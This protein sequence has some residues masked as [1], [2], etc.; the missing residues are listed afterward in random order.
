MKKL[1]HIAS[2]VFLLTGIVFPGSAKNRDGI[3]TSSSVNISNVI[4]AAGT[5]VS[6]PVKVQGLSNIGAISL[7]IPYNS[8]LTFTSITTNTGL[9]F[10][11][12]ASGGVISIAWVDFTGN[13]P[14]TFT[15]GSTLLYLNFT[16][17]SGSAPI[18]FN[19][20]LCQIAD[21]QA[22]PLT[23][24]FNNGGVTLFTGTFPTLSIGNVTGLNNTAVILPLN[25]QNFTN[26]S[27]FT[28]N[29]SY[30]TSTLTYMGLS[31]SYNGIAISNNA[32]S[33][34]LTLSWTDLTGTTPITISNGLLTNLKFTY[35]TGSGAVSFN[36][37]LS[38][39]DNSSGQIIS[40]VIY[41]NGSIAQAVPPVSPI[42]S[43]PL[44]GAINQPV[45]ITLTWGSVPTAQTYRVQISTDSLFATTYKDSSGITSTSVNITSLNNS[46][47][48]YWR[49]NASY[50]GLAGNYSNVSNFTTI[51]AFPTVPVLTSPATNTINQ[52]LSITFNWNAV[53]TAASYRIQAATD[54]LFTAI[55]LNDSTVTT[56]SRSLSGLLNLKKYYW[57]VNAKNLAGTSAYS[58]VSNL[59][60]I[61]AAPASPA[62]TS[63]STGVINQPISL[64]FSWSTVAGAA[65]YNFQ[66]ATDS[67][68]VTPTINDSTLSSTTRSVSGLLNNTKYYWRVNAKNIGGTSG[69]STIWNFKT[70]S[71]PTIS[72]KVLYA[73]TVSQGVKNVIVTLNPGGF[74]STTDASG[75]FSFLNIPNGS[76]TLAASTTNA[77]SNN[78]INA[79]D[80]LWIAQSFV[81]LKTFSTIQ[82]LSADVNVQGGVNNT[83]ALLIIRR[84]AGLTTS[85]PAGDWVFT[86]PT[87][88]VADS[89]LNL[90]IN[91]LF[92]GDV[93]A[94]SDMSTLPKENF[95]SFEEKNVLS[96]KQNEEF[97]IPVVINQDVNLGAMNL[98]FNYPSELATFEGI[99]SSPE[100]IISNEIKGNVKIAWFDISGGQ[101]PLTLKSGNSIVVLRFKSSSAFKADSRFSLQFDQSMC[102][103]ATEEGN[104]LQSVQIQLPSVSMSVPTEFSLMQNYPNPFN[105]TTTIKYVLGYESNVTL[106]IFN[107]LGQS[108]HEYKEGNRQP[109]NNEFN[110]NAAG[111]ASGIYIFSINAQSVDG[112]NNFSAVKKMILM[113]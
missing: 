18:T 74:T 104:I 25:A 87:V 51:I 3:L 70:I 94:S 99:M 89:N 32:V 15:D 6:V 83:D 21:E 90:T 109:G 14:Q 93:N 111:L 2:L 39:V 7:K 1:I 56:N 68:F 108:V 85:F 112:K 5:N 107:S 42:L 13:T 88:T 67:L 58:I 45:S 96:I 28:F 24:S 82:N 48:Y 84:W 33:G 65:S 9:S 71:L 72:G 81:G 49:V 78:E 79:T 101:K 53:P 35:L 37:A 11:S 47:K 80:A 86:Y 60:T 61:I 75:S 57:R 30:N 31:N 62:L 10:I 102:Q 20:T 26:I 52:P 113:K 27:S 4:A 91:C 29:I 77:W 44:T 12:N 95:I 97:D 98:S 69:W 66:L 105:P 36:S 17:S 92:S 110:F 40:G 64:N 76:Y 50:L 16:Y 100:N 34:V 22:V 43:S 19:T 46:T 106:K 8:A 63:P 23:V 41:T 59:T 103:F 38:E 54:S 55:I 73:S